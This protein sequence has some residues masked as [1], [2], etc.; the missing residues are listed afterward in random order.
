VVRK[1]TDV[2]EKRTASTFR[3][4]ISQA[5]NQQQASHKIALFVDKVVRK[6]GIKPNAF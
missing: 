1:F 6:R 4:R 2:L 5:R 3:P